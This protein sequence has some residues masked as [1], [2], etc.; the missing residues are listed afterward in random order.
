MSASS[1][2]SSDDIRQAIESSQSIFSSI[3]QKAVAKAD[4][5]NFDAAAAYGQ[6]A[7]NFAW[8][9]HTGEFASPELEQLLGRVAPRG[10]SARS[11]H[12]RPGKRRKVLHVLTEGY[13]TGGHTQAVSCWIEQDQSSDHLVCISRQA[14]SRTPKKLLERLRSKQDLIHLSTWPGG[15][16]RRAMRLRALAAEV[17]VVLLHTH[18]YD[19]VPVL[20]FAGGFP[21]PVIY[22]NHADHVFWVGAS[23]SSVVM[24]MRESGHVLSVSRRGIERARSLIMSRPLR[25]AGRTL[26]K[27]EARRQLGI[28]DDQILIFT[29]ADEPKYEPIWS[30]TFVDLLIPVIRQNTNAVLLAAGPSMTGQWEIAAQQTGGRIRALGRLNGV[31]VYQQAADIYIDSYPFSSLTSLIEAGSME[32]PAVTFRGHPEECAILG[33]D[34]PGLDEFILKAHDLE[35]FVKTLQ[36]LIDSP[37]ERQRLGR[38]LA[39]AIRDTHTGAQWLQSANELYEAARALC[40]PPGALRARREISEVDLRVARLMATN[41]F[42]TGYAGALENN[43]PLLPL[44][45]RLR[46]LSDPALS[47]RGSSLRRLLPEW[48]Q[49]ALVDVRGLILQPRSAAR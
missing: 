22:V 6:I 28:R 29:A 43:V 34:S 4:S 10:P 44:G 32:V 21:V 12:A 36:A 48:L 27:E 16:V 1:G 24:N 15:L 2:A 25:V 33:S 30:P 31:S 47:A 19:V 49:H 20:A 26:G 18:P 3:L 14:T 5:G 45:E 39:A 23:V 46:V 37:S 42:N 38:A 11:R 8:L 17:D 41:K 9:N 40:S 13:A 7:A 35:E